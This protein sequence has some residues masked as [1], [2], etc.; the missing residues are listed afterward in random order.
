MLILCI[1]LSTLNIHSLIG[2]KVMSYIKWFGQNSFYVMATHFPIKEALGRLVNKIFDC[3]VHTDIK[4]ASLVF[5][6]TLL[7][8]SFVVWGCCWIKEKWNRKN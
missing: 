1:C 5:V 2:L 6:M 7:I 3:D 4:Y 8:D